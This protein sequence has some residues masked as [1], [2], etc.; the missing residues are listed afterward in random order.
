MADRLSGE[1]LRVVV[2]LGANLG[3]R[4]GNLR[5]A[6]AAIGKV[7]RIERLSRVYETAPVLPGTPEGRDTD[8][9]HP[10]YLNAAAL[11][12]YRGSPEQLLAALQGI[13]AQ[14]GRVRK[15]GDRWAP[16]PIDLD[17]LWIE[18]LQCESADLVVPHPRLPE[19]AFALRPLVDVAPQ[20]VDPWTQMPYAYLALHVQGDVK[21]TNASLSLPS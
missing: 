19:R 1:G 13:E 9:M 8:P 5:A 12:G 10:P 21:P 2:G 7:A 15:G 18:G 14:L 11:V 17:I 3:D 4:G 6:V 20:A 16:R